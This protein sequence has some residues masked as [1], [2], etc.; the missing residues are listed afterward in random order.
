MRDFLLKEKWGKHSEELVKLTDLFTKYIDKK[1]D[2]NYIFKDEEYEKLK[3]IFFKEHASK[4]FYEYY[5]SIKPIINP[6]GII[7]N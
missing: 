7:I 1:Y 3:D 2:D 5:K 6:E 4:E